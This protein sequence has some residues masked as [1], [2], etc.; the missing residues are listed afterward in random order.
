MRPRLGP[1][2]LVK[3][4]K[5]APPPEL[6][7][8][9]AEEPPVVTEPEPAAP[10]PG[11]AV[12]PAAPEPEPARPARAIKTR[13]TVRIEAPDLARHP[14]FAR[15]RC[16][17]AVLGPGEMLFIPAGTWHYVRSL[18]PSLSVNFWF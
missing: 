16:T 4:P 17:E 13:R 11:E 18:T 9:V 14:R 15:A 1:P 6:E 2:R 10:E 8:E 7:D 12:E 3:A 5:P